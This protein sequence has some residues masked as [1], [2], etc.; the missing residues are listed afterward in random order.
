MTRR[1]SRRDISRLIRLIDG[2]LSEGSSARLRDRLRRDSALSQ[3]HR[4]LIEARKELAEIRDAATPE[5]PYRQI[6][7]QARWRA[8]QIA[9]P[10]AAE[11]RADT[12]RVFSVRPVAALT[13][14][15]CMGGIVTLGVVQLA[16][17]IA[18]AEALVDKP[19]TS[20]GTRRGTA[21]LR[22]MNSQ[23]SRCSFRGVSASQPVMV[24]FPRSRPIVQCWSAS[25]S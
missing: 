13:I 17:M 22:P 7:A 4:R 23:R 11:M 9:E 16:T 6:E 3:A 21:L 20:P 12:S 14:A 10:P 2:S 5:L 8:A 15:A 18:G 24:V 19:A 1:V 25:A